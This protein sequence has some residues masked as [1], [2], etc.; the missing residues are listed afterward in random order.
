MLRRPR[1]NKL[2]SRFAEAIAQFDALNAEDPN[3]I[4][5]S[6]TP[7]PKELV[8]AQRMTARLIAFQ[9][10]ASEALRLAARCQHI[11]RWKI[12]R[13]AYATGPMGYKKWRN[14]L[15]RLHAQTATS[16]LEAVGYEPE[17]IE[18]VQGLLKKRG[19]KSEPDVQ[20]L[21]DVACL[22]FLEHYA[23]D[24]A[25]KHDEEKVVNILQKTWKKMSPAG[26]AAALELKLPDAVGQLVSRA[27]AT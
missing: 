23:V 18:A 26:H 25:S 20:A 14:E 17:I 13:N 3:T 6:G 2:M 27:L 12:P 24:F 21:E 10:A 4:D 16:V 19:L 8:Y 11:Q 1:K 5:V 7:T 22:V 9:P 15:K